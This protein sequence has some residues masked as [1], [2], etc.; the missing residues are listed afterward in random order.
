MEL[1]PGVLSHACVDCGRWCRDCRHEHSV[2][3][4]CD[5]CAA[6]Y[7]DNPP[8]EDGRVYC[9]GDG[10]D[11]DAFPPV[12]P[13]GVP[14]Y[15]RLCR[16]CRERA[17]LG[18]QEAAEDR[19]LDRRVGVAA[20]LNGTPRPTQP[21][22]ADGLPVPLGPGGRPRRNPA[23]RQGGAVPAADQH[24]PGEAPGQATAWARGGFVPR[25]PDATRRAKRPSEMGGEG[26]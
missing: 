4:R 2:P 9:R 26:L 14:R 25:Q 18:R 13:S 10:C 11:A 7:R 19:D 24:P 16:S 1:R 6:P 21:T 23:P 17:A 20:V 22:D 8:A 12:L 3:A 5:G 15:P